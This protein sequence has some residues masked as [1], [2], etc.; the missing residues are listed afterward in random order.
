VKFTVVPASKLLER[1]SATELIRSNFKDVATNGGRFLLVAAEAGIG[2]TSILRAIY[3]NPNQPKNYWGWCE[4]LKT[5][6]PLGPLMDVMMALDPAIH[7][8][9]LQGLIEDSQPE[10]TA[11]SRVYLLFNTVIKAL[12]NLREPTSLIFEDVHWA[13][14]VTLDFIKFLGRRIHTLPL[15]FI[16]SYRPDEVIRDHPLA[17]VLGELPSEVVTRLQLEP[18]S[19]QAVVQLVNQKGGDTKPTINQRQLESQGV[20]RH[21]LDGQAL[22]HLTKGNPYFVT[23]ILSA[24]Q[25]EKLPQSVTQAALARA[26]SLP[27]PARAAFDVVSIIPGQAEYSMLMDILT[28]AEQAGLTDCIDSGVLRLDR[29]RVLFRHELGRLAAESAIAP[30]SKRKMHQT[31]LSWLQANR[32]NDV[33]LIAYHAAEVWDGA[34]VLA[35][36]PAAARQ[37]A[38]LG[39]HKEAVAHYQRALKFKDRLSDSECAAL[40]EAW[41]YECGISGKIDQEVVNA[42]QEALR[43]RRQ[44]NDIEAIGRNLYWMARMLWYMGEGARAAELSRDAV[45][46][47]Q[48]V[49]QSAAYALALSMRSQYLMLNEQPQEAITIGHQA[50]EL[51]RD[52]KLTETLVHSLNT[53]GTA[54]LSLGQTIGYACLE[55]SLQLALEH[56]LHEQAARAYTNATWSALENRNYQQAERYAVEGI[57]FDTEHELISWTPYLVGLY[58]NLL[59]NQ[60]QLDAAALEANRALAMPNLSVVVRL[61]A[62]CVL[63]RI[64]SIKG[65]ERALG[66]FNEARK[67]AEPTGEPM[68]IVKPVLFGLIEYFWL[69]GAISEAMQVMADVPTWKLESKWDV[70][71]ACIWKNRLDAAPACIAPGWEISPE[72]PFSA[73]AGE[74]WQEARTNWMNIGAA[75]DS[76][77]LLLSEA[78][79]ESIHECVAQAEKIGATQYMLRA[80]QLARE[81]GIKGIRRGANASARNNPLGLT[82]R[83]AQMLELLQAGLSNKEIANR[84][85]R[86]ERTIEHHTS[87]LF[88]K[89][90]VTNR[91]Q[92]VALATKLTRH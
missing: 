2:K 83:E 43:I 39:A 60:G 59:M 75:L 50:I 72:T 44:Q 81:I 28:A 26:S 20:Q 23:E 53:V 92:A 84:L 42:S 29:D 1:E 3:N 21:G 12:G 61:P 66:L 82:P 88:K 15:Q 87:A 80:R 76:L 56:H 46:T 70:S 54:H 78:T 5:P 8:E 25:A 45:E 68:R 62:M 71:E 73:E 24:D 86:S 22:F 36:A 48:E 55:E 7:H 57:R 6:R 33:A 35:T 34:L 40:L 37:A 58:A 9:I 31:V 11:A 14:Q 89:L 49:P 74:R 10:R 64:Y 16:L 17:S 90:E 13:D 51:A 77:L 32:P 63:A 18:L 52:L 67:L 79:E 85:S 38:A 30:A 19:L 91:Q 27:P 69:R 4:Q 47:L 41:A 65:D